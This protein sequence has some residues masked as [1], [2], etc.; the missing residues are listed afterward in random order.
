MCFVESPAVQAS[1]GRERWP[2]KEQVNSVGKCRLVLHLER[3]KCYI[4]SSV[5]TRTSEAT[6]A[7]QLLL[8]MYVGR[9]VVS[10]LV[11]F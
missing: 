11:C 10:C 2:F 6:E 3:R 5:L 8:S 1:R 9:I 4:S 7:V